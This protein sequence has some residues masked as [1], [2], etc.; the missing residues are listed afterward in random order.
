MEK[1]FRSRRVIGMCFHATLG[2]FLTGYNQGVFNPCQNN[3]AAT[4]NWGSQKETLVAL[5]SAF[6]PIGGT[7]GGMLAGVIANKLGRR[8]AMVFL[9]ALSCVGAAL[10]MVPTTVTFGIGRLVGGFISGAFL[11]IAPVYISEV[12][13]PEISGRLGSLTQGNFALGIAVS[14]AL[15]LP[16]P[17]SD[18]NSSSMNEWWI[19][20]FGFQILVA[21]YLIGGYLFTYKFDTP[22]WLLEKGRNQEFKEA[23]DYVYTP[24]GLP[25]AMTY[26]SKSESTEAFLEEP[27][28]NPSYKDLFCNSKYRKMMRL[29]IL[30]AVF[31]PFTGA[32]A[33]IFY[34][35]LMFE[36]ISDNEFMARVYTFILG[37]VNTLSV[38]LSLPFVD[39]VGR[40]KMLVIGLTL[41]GT[42]LLLLGLSELL[43]LPI[44]LSVTLLIGFCV[45]WALSPGPILWLYLG[46][47][48]TDK[49]MSV[50]ITVCHVCISIVVFTFPFLGNLVSLSGT[51]L[52]YAGVS[53]GGALYLVFDM[54]ETKGIPRKKIFN[55]ITSKN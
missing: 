50:A 29:S 25:K 9:S 12:S 17:T 15:G 10:C 38:L 33:I 36:K 14:Y 39:K 40:K 18:Y 1:E 52:I 47:I 42:D 44:E 31:L 41:L 55:Q 3:V 4:L 7:V 16:L 11:A 51:F 35:T 27:E 30:L 13:P 49:G 23:L 37:V 28:E 54:V 53:F 6:N 5:F 26:H 45:V 21:L 22:F 34:S 43:N 8:K 2:P 24:E 46:E 19:L 48:L 20:M 32:A